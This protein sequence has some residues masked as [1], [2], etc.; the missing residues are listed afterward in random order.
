MPFFTAT[1]LLIPFLG[2]CNAV[3]FI[4]STVTHNHA[5]STSS[6]TTVYTTHVHSTSSTSTASSVLSTAAASVSGVPAGFEPGVKWQIEI[7]D[8]VDPR[9]G[10]RPSDA[11][12]VDVDL[13][14]AS[15]DLTLIPALHVSNIW[16][17]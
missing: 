15:K 17:I 3:P 1:A 6:V 12:V 8:P 14:Q 10:L 13:F 4:T 9:G 7:Q 11:K 16:R 5:K 2:L